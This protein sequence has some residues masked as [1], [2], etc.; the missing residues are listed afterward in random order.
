[1]K[2]TDFAHRT[3]TF[4]LSRFPTCL[5]ALLLLAPAWPFALAVRAAEDLSAT[6]QRGLFEEEANNNLPAAIKAYEAVVAATDAQRKL[7][8]TALFRLAEC[9][10]KLGRTND[11]VA[12]YQRVL[13]EYPDQTRLVDLSRQYVVGL[14]ASAG[15]GTLAQS[16][17]QPARA[18]QKRLLEEEIKI[19]EKDLAELEQQRKVGVVSAGALSAKQREL[20]ALRRQVAAL[21]VETVDEASRLAVS[22]PTD[23]EDKEVR[24]IQALIKDSPDL[25]NAGGEGGATPLH[26]AAGK[27]QLVVAKFLLANNANVNA[28]NQRNATPLHEAVF[29]GHKSMAELLLTNGA[30]V[31][32]ESYDGTALHA[33]ASRGFNAIVEVLLANKANPNAVSQN[34]ATPL[35]AAVRKGFK[36]V[37]AGLLEA[38]ADVNALEKYPNL[39]GNPSHDLGT[40]LHLAVYRGNKSLVEMILARKP[41]VNLRNQFGETPL[42]VVGNR[43]EL[44][45]LLVAAK[46][47]VNA[48]VREEGNEFSNTPL[49]IAVTGTHADMVEFLL[50]NGADPNVRFGHNIRNYY[51][52]HTPLTAAVDATNPNERIIRALLEHKADTGA[53]KGNGYAPLHLAAS[54]ASKLATELLLKHGVNVEVRDRDGGN[55]PLCLVGGGK[56]I[57]ELL[58][59]HKANPNAQN[60]EGNTALHKLAVMA[61]GRDP[62][63]NQKEIAELL[64]ARGADVNIRNRQGLTPLNLFGV[65]AQAGTPSI[66]ELVE[67]LRKHG[68]KDEQLDLV[69][70]PDSIRVWRKG[71][72]SGRVVFVRDEAGHNRFTLMEALMNFYSLRYTPPTVADRPA[73]QTRTP[74]TTA[75]GQLSFPNTPIGQGFGGIPAR[76][77]PVGGQPAVVAFGGAPA[78]SYD[79]LIEFTFPDLTRIRILRLV[80]PAKN[81]KKVIPVNLINA[82]GIVLCANDVL[83]EF[84]DIIE[85]PVREYRLDEGRSGI[86]SDQNKQFSD[87]MLRNVQVVVKSEA[88]N[89]KLLPQSSMAY[90]ASAMKLNPVRNV[91]RS[92]SDLSRLRITRRADPAINQPAGELTVDLEA[93]QRNN[94]QQ[95]DDLWLRDGDII[96]VPE[97]E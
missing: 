20:L 22:T 30:D 50:K 37:V 55:T 75:P 52:Q 46:A 67:V 15:A 63:N 27:G 29:N 86:T 83:L 80:D 32:A 56:E 69:A 31:N 96:E 53:P 57:I 35:H 38:G 34:N 4:S 9:N 82:A 39:S 77:M 62:V 10:R 73:A 61:N 14:G 41:D 23:E 1:M 43:V 89:V 54:N 48:R 13:R 95:W 93:F 5:L 8:G 68:A 42:Q 71:M 24:R 60:N 28:R 11:A 94:K 49:T 40:P 72:T 36:T 79:P 76:A 91:L 51:T 58:L 74:R 47:D 92:T 6:L 16:L 19:V 78:S 88:T 18:E 2:T 84:G 59:D 85:I 65:P 7:A 70:D 26:K 12:F 25:I 66:V 3:P 81:E 97:R 64:I 44:A 33:A 90:L 17:S 21:G 45:S 87:C